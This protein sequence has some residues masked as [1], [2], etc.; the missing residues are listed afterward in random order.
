M[1]SGLD[2]AGQADGEGEGEGGEEQGPVGRAP[3]KGAKGGFWHTFHRAVLARAG[4]STGG[5]GG[6]SWALR[7]GA[8][9]VAKA[10]E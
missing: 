1:R 3:D 4:K 8:G 5:G 2:G 9:R 6:G 10:D 7:P